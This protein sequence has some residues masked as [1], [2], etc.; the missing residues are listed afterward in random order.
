MVGTS[1]IYLSFYKLLLCT[2]LYSRHIKVLCRPH[3]VGSRPLHSTPI[4]NCATI[5]VQFLLKEGRQVYSRV[6]SRSTLDLEHCNYKNT[7]DDMR[8]DRL[9]CGIRDTSVQR[10]LLA[11][12]DL[13]FKK[14]MELAQTVHGIAIC[15]QASMI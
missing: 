1:C 2:W 5:P 10:R 6:C 12:P 14:A 8:R 11:E 7:L 15:I 4:N 9:M 13:T 3:K